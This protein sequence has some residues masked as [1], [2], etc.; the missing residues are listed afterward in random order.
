MVAE[1][2]NEPRGSG[3]N[4]FQITPSL[5]SISPASTPAGGA[6]LRLTVTGTNFLKQSVISVNG[7]QYPTTFASASSLNAMVKPGS[8]A[9]AWPVCVI[10]PVTAATISTQTIPWTFT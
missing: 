9:G 2:I 5:S 10:T 4:P 6:P 3:S 8:T 1:S 7:V